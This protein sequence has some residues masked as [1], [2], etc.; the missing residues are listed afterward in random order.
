MTSKIRDYL[1]QWR[2]MSFD[3]FNTHLEEIATFDKELAI[4]IKDV[5]RATDIVKKILVRRYEGK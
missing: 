3:H 2:N 5:Y 4:A 1:W